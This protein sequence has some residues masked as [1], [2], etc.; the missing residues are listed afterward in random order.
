MR[1]IGRS[2]CAVGV[3]G[4]LFERSERY[5]EDFT[6]RLQR[7]HPQAKVGLP[8]LAPYIGAV[9]YYFL[10]KNELTQQVVANLRATAKGLQERM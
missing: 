4:G 5:R 8:Q 2:D 7:I 10:K 9:V 3:F 6:R 1:A